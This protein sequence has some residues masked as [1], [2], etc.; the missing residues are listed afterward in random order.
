MQTCP[1]CG[2]PVKNLQQWHNCVKV[3]MDSLFEGKKP[4]LLFIFDQIL[5]EVADWEGVSVSATKNCIVFVRTHTFL[6]VKPMKR[7]LDVKFYLPEK[8]DEFPIVK[9]AEWSPGKWEHHVRLQEL[10]EVTEVVFKFLKT[11]Y[12][13]C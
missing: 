6:I 9:N 8:Q 4:D 10:E 12:R 7:A 3:E 1:Q 5:A 11:S 13:M 2:R